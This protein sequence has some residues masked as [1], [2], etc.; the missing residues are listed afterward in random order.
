MD[1]W[2]VGTLA[3]RNKKRAKDIPPKNNGSIQKEEGQTFGDGS[4]DPV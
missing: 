1:K 4:M 3:V 2:G